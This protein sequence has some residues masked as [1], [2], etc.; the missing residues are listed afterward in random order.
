MATSRLMVKLLKMAPNTKLQFIRACS[1]G[2]S[3]VVRE[4]LQAGM[5]PETRDDYGLTGL[6]WVGRKGNIQIA[7]ILLDAG[8]DI[9]G[10][11]RRGRTSL[12][13]AVIFKRY[14]FVEF[15]AIRHASINSTDLHGCTP[16]DLASMP[17]DKK[18]VRLL[19]EKGAQRRLSEE[20]IASDKGNSFYFGAGPGGPDL[21]IEVERVHIQFAGLM[22]QWSGNYTEAIRTFGFMMYVDGSLIRY[23]ET[24]NILGPQKAKRKR[25]WLEVKIG[26]PE[27]WWREDEIHYKQRIAAAIEDGFTSMIALLIRNKYQID[28][29]ALKRDWHHLKTEFLNTP[30]PPFAA[31]GQRARLMARVNEG[32]IAVSAE[33]KKVSDRRARN[34]RQP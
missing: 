1:T 26:V 15:L 4:L 32:S 31:E 18:M 30:A 3:Q 17:L 23:T 14:A 13:H 24:M 10:K 25:D 19:K 21:P 34:G 5:S 27:S 6:I 22:R 28:D 7:E 8:A 12:H 16:L 20:P 9:E 11:D 2:K 29:S 33:M